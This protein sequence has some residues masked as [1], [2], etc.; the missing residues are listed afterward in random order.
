MRTSSEQ[1]TA[2]CAVKSYHAIGQDDAFFPHELMRK[3][4]VRVTELQVVTIVPYAA[5]FA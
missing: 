1:V 5:A 3:S 2:K 4:I